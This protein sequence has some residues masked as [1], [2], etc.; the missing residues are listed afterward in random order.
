MVHA[1]ADSKAN[2]S[3]DRCAS[4]FSEGDFEARLEPHG[5]DELGVL[6]DS[7][8]R[9]AGGIIA[10]MKEISRKEYF[11]Q[12]LL[13]GIPDGIRVIDQNYKIVAVNTAYLEQTGEAKEGSIGSPCYSVVHGRQEPCPPTLMSCPLH[14]VKQSAQPVKVLHR[15]F[16]SLGSAL[17]VEIC[18]AP[19]YMEQ[20][21]AAALYIVEVIRDINKTVRYSQEQRLSTLGQLAAGV[22]HEVHN[23]LGSIQIA[24]RSLFH[25]VTKD[26]KD[27]VDSMQIQKYLKLVEGEIDTCVEVT[28]R[29]LKLSATPGNVNQLIELNIAVDETISLLAWEAQSRGIDNRLELAAEQPRVVAS[30]SEM[31]M[32]VLN[33]VQNAFHAMPEGGALVVKTSRQEGR[34]MLWV[35]DDGC[36]IAADVLPRIFDPFFSARADQKRG[37]GLGLAICKAIVER[38]GGSIKVDSVVGQGTVFTVALPDPDYS[39]G[40]NI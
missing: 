35:A 31:R 21:D 2:Q 32:V 40:S 20:S 18:A 27:A 34:S 28:N 38:A 26:T 9:M 3:F 12:S 17:D 15:H 39:A 14:E 29:L 22:A 36:G 24:L 5:S 25:E 8:N 30:D 7:F 23:P 6:A 37:T 33:M 16:R 19:V 11:L 1:S 10:S 13:D 4:R